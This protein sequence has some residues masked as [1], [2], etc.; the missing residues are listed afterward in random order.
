[1]QFEI[2]FDLEMKPSATSTE[3]SRTEPDR[4]AAKEAPSDPRRRRRTSESSSGTTS[5]ENAPT[6]TPAPTTPRKS[7]KKEEPSSKVRRTGNK[8]SL[9]NL[10]R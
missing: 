5:K 10:T 9:H 6:A 2:L 3:K 1:M 8:G 4:K 7:P